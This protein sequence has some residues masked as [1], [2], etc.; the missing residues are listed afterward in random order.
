[1]PP[2]YRYAMIDLDGTLIDALAFIHASVNDMLSRLS[3][4]Q[5]TLSMT[6]QA[7]GAPLLDFLAACTR[8]AF[9]I[10][11]R[12]DEHA[13]W[14]AANSAHVREAY[15]E[16][17][18]S[19]NAKYITMYDGVP[20]GLQT[21]IDHGVTLA[22]VTNRME[23]SAKKTLAS[24]GLDRFFPV[25]I[26]NGTYHVT[27]PNAFLGERLVTD[28]GFR[29]EHA[30]MIGDG[31]TDHAFAQNVGAASL[32]VTYGMTEEDALRE[33]NARHYAASF[34]DAVAQTIG[35]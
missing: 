3:L 27:K 29:M 17:H 8:A 31:R 4:A 34:A 13:A 32:L 14:F 35:P 6:K 25:V 21:L 7:M 33:C 2:R 11:T 16:D 23:R 5:I 10:E 18:T 20:E 9:T 24:F 1:M 28:H 12:D 19:E 22:L 15:R 26:G 30:V